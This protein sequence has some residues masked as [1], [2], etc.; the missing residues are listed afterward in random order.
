MAKR[1]E[2]NIVK[3]TGLEAALAPFSGENTFENATQY[4]SLP[5]V[6]IIQQMT[7][8]DLK[9]E[10]GEGTAIIRPGNGVLCEA[11]GEV[12]VTPVHFYTEYLKISDRNDD[13]NPMIMERD[14][15]PDSDLA[16]ICRD[17]ERRIEMY[18]EDAGKQKPRYWRHVESL[19]FAMVIND[20]NHPL[21]G[22]Q[23][24]MSFSK[25]SY[26]IGRELL[27]AM[28][29]RRIRVVDPNHATL[30]TTVSQPMWSQIWT[31]RGAVAENKEGDKYYVLKWGPSQ[32]NS[33][34]PEQIDQ[35]SG[36]YTE[37][38]KAYKERR[39]RQEYEQEEPEASV[40][41]GEY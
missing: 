34:E 14:L 32:P 9:K 25:G 15:N 2:S 23:F 24:M 28:R 35:M 16:K 12:M 36:L 21:N 39:L 29:M 19:N 20:P 38:Q 7:D 33:I 6:K 37:L 41:S 30:T 13:E 26:R 18:P 11:D 17:Y 1:T 8:P 27:D 40:G 4:V 5:R 3:I 22:Q 10:F 31:L